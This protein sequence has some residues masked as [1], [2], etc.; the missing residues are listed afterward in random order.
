MTKGNRRE[1]PENR[2]RGVCSRLSQNLGI[3]PINNCIAYMNG[4]ILTEADKI[5]NG[6]KSDSWQAADI[7]MEMT[8]KLNSVMDRWPKAK[9]KDLKAENTKRQEEKIELWSDP[10]YVLSKE[11]RKEAKEIVN[12]YYKNKYSRNMDSEAY[13]EFCKIVM[14]E[15]KTRVGAGVLVGFFE[16]IPLWDLM[17]KGTDKGFAWAEEQSGGEI[18]YT[19]SEQIDIIEKQFPTATKVGEGAGYILQFLALRGILAEGKTGK[20]LE[21]AGEGMIAKMGL[22]GAAKA[23]AQKTAKSM[24][25]VTLDTMVDTLLKTIP[26]AIVNGID[27]KSAEEIAKEALAETGESFA[28]NIT[29][30][31]LAVMVENIAKGI[32]KD[33]EFPNNLDDTCNG[34][35][36]IMVEGGTVP[37]GTL[38]GKLD[39]LTTAERTMVD[40]LLN[41]GNN[42]EIIPRSNIPGNK[43]PD[44]LVNGV[45]TELKTLTGTSL[46]TPVTRIQDGFKQ[47]A[48]AVI[49]DGRNTGL[50]L[51]DANTVIERALGKYGGELPGIVEIWTT[52]GIIR[53]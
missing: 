6:Q 13:E 40:D 18:G 42:V 21:K 38:T 47:G 14:I 28:Y 32:L 19:F 7:A 16:S 10:E 11:E 45:K 53:R 34:E 31:V 8:S 9:M 22:E 30:E 17:E 46:N 15:N 27:G 33:K 25:N 52:E 1:N 29:G 36:D 20:A 39:G 41:A 3:Q 44:F 2:R 50:T 43:T 48:E 12:D 35:S 4:A 26:H 51:D 24:V 5:L 49:I 23:A 37:K